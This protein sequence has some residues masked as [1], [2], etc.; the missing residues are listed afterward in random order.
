MTLYDQIN[1]LTGATE[2]AP[3]LARFGRRVSQGTPMR[4]DEAFSASF[5]RLRAGETPGF[6][7]FR[8][9]SRFDS[10]LQHRRSVRR[11]ARPRSL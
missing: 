10:V 11:R 3:E 9:Q 6:P 2:W 8:P 4:L 5:R 1:T 7:R